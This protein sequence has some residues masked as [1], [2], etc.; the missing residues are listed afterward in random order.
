MPNALRQ[1]NEAL[2][3]AYLQAVRGLLRTGASPDLATVLREVVDRTGALT[4]AHG[5][6]TIGGERDTSQRCLS[7]G[8][9]SA[10][11]ATGRVDR[12]A[13]VVRT[14]PAGESEG[15]PRLRP[16]ARN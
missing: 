2:A 6:I 8:L 15:L 7:S 11:Q 1:Q 4:G 5:A 14:P 16:V 12:R 3:G 13:A 9:T 10:E